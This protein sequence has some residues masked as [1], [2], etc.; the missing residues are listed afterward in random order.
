ML[1]LSGLCPGR[2]MRAWLCVCVYMR[3]WRVQHLPS[4]PKVLGQ[5]GIPCRLS[6]APRRRKEGTT[7]PG[8][9]WAQA[10]T[11]SPGGTAGAAQRK[12]GTSPCDSE[13]SFPGEPPPAETQ[14]ATCP[15][16]PY[17]CPMMPQRPHSQARGLEEESWGPGRWMHPGAEN[18]WDSPGRVNWAWLHCD[19][20]RRKLMADAELC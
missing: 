7:H 13:V 9:T 3:A 20:S 15:G 19:S 10:A 4:P 12:P 5:P 18:S 14:R 8:G 2:Q 16:P 6:A 1:L 11:A 17:C